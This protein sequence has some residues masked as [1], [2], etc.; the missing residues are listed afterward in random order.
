MSGSEIVVTKD[1]KLRGKF[2]FSTEGNKFRS[3]L[4]IPY[5]EPPIGKRRFTQPKPPKSW[6]G[7]R[8]ALTC[9]PDCA[10]YDPFTR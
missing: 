5:A 3:F 8:T 10:Q 4:G 6:S 7:I 2:D 1:G 9:G